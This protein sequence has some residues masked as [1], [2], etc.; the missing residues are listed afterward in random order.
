MTLRFMFAIAFCVVAFSA[1]AAEPAD[2]TDVV[3]PA[4]DIARGAVIAEGDLINKSIAVLRVNDGI[5][6]NA[7]DAAGKEAKRALRAGEFLRNSDLKRP[8]LVAKGST[9]TMVFESPGIHLT[10]VGRALAE[11]GEGDTIAVLN[12]TSYRQ[13]AAVV[14]APGTVRVGPAI[15][16]AKSPKEVAAARQ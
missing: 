15:A 4:H 13:V 1:F 16:N 9:V 8:A 11:G 3:V 10:A 5:V 6:R 14:T 2:Q 7:S 12:P